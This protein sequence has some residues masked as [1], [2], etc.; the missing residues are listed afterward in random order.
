MRFFSLLLGSIMNR[1]GQR[2]QRNKMNSL[3]IK[4]SQN[5]ILILL[6]LAPIN[7]M[8]RIS[9]EAPLV[10]SKRPTFAVLFTQHASD[11]SEEYENLRDVAQFALETY[12][13]ESKSKIEAKLVG[14]DDRD[15]PQFAE[16]ALR[17]LVKE[18]R[19]AAIIG[20]MYSNVAM[21]LKD[22]I[23]KN[24]IPMMS[25]FA[26]HNDLTKNCPFMF[27]ICASN[28]RLVK[29]MAEFLVPEAKKHALNITA[30]KDLDD[31]YSMDLVDTFRQSAESIKTNYNEVLFRGI[32]GL[33]RLKDLNSKIWSPTK[34]D[35][36]FLPVQDI[37]AGTIVA[38]LES[39]PYLIAAVD[40][41]NFLHLMTKLKNQKSH[42]RLVTTTQ[43][44]PQKSDFSKKIEAAFLTRFKRPMTITSALTFDATFTILKA[45]DR[46][47]EKS[48]PLDVALK[49]STKFSGVTGLILIGP[50]GERVFSDQFLKD[51]II[52]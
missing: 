20:P 31:D 46:A 35:I 10:N 42:I 16:N 52:E 2:D 33:E 9:K 34:K 1:L 14:V 19:P 28:R 41:V 18:D 6:L 4:K 50:D 30:F 23:S 11:N 40:T 12:K 29:S 32:S 38:S 43:W 3:Y 22:F 37:V 45:Y 44:L 48:I 47:V 25:I 5:L 8:A 21:G 26:T 13:E 15:D 24:K 7:L 36:F 51:E 27:R 39:E 49:D 17:K